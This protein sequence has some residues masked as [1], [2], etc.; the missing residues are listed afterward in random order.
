MNYVIYDVNECFMLLQHPGKLRCKVNSAREEHKECGHCIADGDVHPKPDLLV[1]S[2][3]LTEVTCFSGVSR[4]DHCGARAS[5]SGACARS[6]KG[7]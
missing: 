6:K 1:P 7:V 4:L 3:E 5:E 2:L